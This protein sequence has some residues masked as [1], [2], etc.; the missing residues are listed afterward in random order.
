MLIRAL[1]AM[2]P[3]SSPIPEASEHCIDL[4]LSTLDC[5]TS[6]AMDPAETA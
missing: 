6:L 3:T 1:T 5:I 4:Q 2:S